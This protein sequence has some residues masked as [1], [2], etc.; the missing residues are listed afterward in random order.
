MFAIV[1]G[2]GLQYFRLIFLVPLLSIFLYDK[3][4]I[5]V[6][7]LIF[8]GFLGFSLTYLCFPSFHREDWK[9]L[10]KNLPHNSNV[11]MV[12]S[13]ADPVIYYRPDIKVN[14]IKHLPIYSYSKFNIIPYG[15][16]IHGINHLDYLK[17]LTQTSTINTNQLSL[18]VWSHP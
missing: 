8:I 9:G 10:L 2:G 6:N 18:E 1:T 17:G 3:K 15:E 11:F 13:F 7:I 12:P 4:S 14:N 5:F 16:A